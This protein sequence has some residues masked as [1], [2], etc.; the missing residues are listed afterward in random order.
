MAEI[1]QELELNYNLQEKDFVDLKMYCASKN[2]KI[3]R[4]RKINR[5]I[6]TLVCVVIGAIYM[7]QGRQLTSTYFL[8]MGA[9]CF[10]IYPWYLNWLYRRMYKK[11]VALT[12]FP[13]HVWLRIDD[14][15]IVTLARGVTTV[16]QLKDITE[17][18]E[19]DESFYLKKSITEWVTIPKTE[20]KNEDEVR[21]FLTSVSL[22]NGITYLEEKRFKWK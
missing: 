8:L 5:I 22:I 12:E 18:I 21:A 14:S 7:Y 11:Q 3:N 16:I 2:D 10:A 15:E 13:V 4:Q 6:T 17:I 1:S 20:L 19:L 9:V